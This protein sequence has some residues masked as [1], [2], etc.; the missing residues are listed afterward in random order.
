MLAYLYFCII[1][2]NRVI[3]SIWNIYINKLKKIRN[4]RLKYRNKYLNNLV[5]KDIII[6]Y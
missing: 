5:G 6:I 4:L 1:K 2:K 3:L